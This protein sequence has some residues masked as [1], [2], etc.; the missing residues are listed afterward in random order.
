MAGETDEAGW[1]DI[2]SSHVDNGMWRP[3][4]GGEL[5][6]RWD[7]GKT[8]IYSGVSQQLAEQTLSSWSVGKA[9]QQIKRGGFAHRYDGEG[10]K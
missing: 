7:S 3:D 1:R 5:V 8:S 6:I 10:E 9:L 4:N 2:Y